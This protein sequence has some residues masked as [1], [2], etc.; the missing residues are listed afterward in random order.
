MTKI[1]NYIT[2]IRTSWTWNHKLL[3][4]TMSLAL[5]VV[6]Q[7]GIIDPYIPRIEAS[8]SIEVYIAPV[9][10]E[11]ATST[12]STRVEKRAQEMY[13]QNEA[14]DLEKYR[15]EAI[16]EINDELLVLTGD[17]PFVDYEAL[18]EQYGY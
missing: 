6:I 13:K 1:K 8:N 18:K 7:S 4:V 17:S 10:T 11:E 12:L 14:M 15:Q 2:T 5:A 16:R 9:E 3:V